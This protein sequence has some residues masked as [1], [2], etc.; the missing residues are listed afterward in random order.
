MGLLSLGTPLP[1]HEA[2]K[3]S[4]DVRRQGVAQFLEIWRRQRGRRGDA[5]L[6]GDEI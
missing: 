5:L 4:D 1:W 2:Q 3:Y 6:W